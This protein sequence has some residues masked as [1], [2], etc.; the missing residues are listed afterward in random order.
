MARRLQSDWPN[1]ITFSLRVGV[2]TSLFNRYTSIH[3]FR[4]PLH[5]RSFTVFLRNNARQHQGSKT[6]QTRSRAACALGATGVT[7]ASSLQTFASKAVPRAQS[8]AQRRGIALPIPDRVFNSALPMFWPTLAAASVDSP[9]TVS[10]AAI[11][12]FVK[13]PVPAAPERS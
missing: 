1:Y 7:P 13:S 2:R 6:Q 9:S 3:N 10:Q 12:L 8:C 5:E 4:P 11:R